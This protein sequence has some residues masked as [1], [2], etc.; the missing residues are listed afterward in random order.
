[1]GHGTWF[2]YIPGL[3]ML[4]AWVCG[5]IMVTFL[6]AFFSRAAY[7]TFRKESLIPSGRLSLR[8]LADLIVEMLIR[9][10]D[11]VM[12]KEGR[13]YLPLLGSLFLFI[14]ISNLLGLI[15]GFSP[16]TGNLNTNFAC[17]IVVYLYYNYC[18]FKEHGLGYF[19]QFMGPLIFLAPIMFAVEMVSHAVRPISLSLRLFGNINGD[20]QIMEVMSSLV[21]LGVPAIFYGLG[22]FVSFMQAFIFVLLSMVYIAMATSHEH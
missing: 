19:K 22:L 4:P 21:P 11:T 13:R 2:D 10:V 8:E 1:M 14:F 3:K 15:P 5:A 6:L 12:G 20:H 18:G 17:S 7:T 9:F 16:P